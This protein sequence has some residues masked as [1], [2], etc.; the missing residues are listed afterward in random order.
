M[1]AKDT[2]IRPELLGVA[3]ISHPELPMGQAISIEQAAISFEAG[4]REV[5]EWMAGNITWDWPNDELLFSSWLKEK[6]L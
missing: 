1:E 4:M 6:G 3:I 5:V 2:V